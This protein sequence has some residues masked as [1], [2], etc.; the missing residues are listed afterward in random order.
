[1][2]AIPVGDCVSVAFSSAYPNPVIGGSVR[3]DLTS[4]CP[5][6]VRWMVYSSAYR[7]I[8]ERT[9]TVLGRVPVEWTLTDAKGKKV[10]AGLYYLVFKPVGQKQEIR[11]VI[12]VR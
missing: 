10:S 9:V 12:V 8:D 4:G 11:L 5:K 7:K 3:V 6:N 2:T 1:M